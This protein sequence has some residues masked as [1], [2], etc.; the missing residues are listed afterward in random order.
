MTCKF[1]DLATGMAGA[2]L[3]AMAVPGE[4]TAAVMPPDY[5]GA[6]NSVFAVFEPTDTTAG[7]SL[8]DFDPVGDEFPLADVEPG[9]DGEA[10][11]IPNFIDP[12][13]VK[14]MRISLE[15][16]TST[17]GGIQGNDIII[18]P[19]DDFQAIEDISFL[20]SGQVLNGQSDVT[21][22]VFFDFRIL[23][24]PDWETVFIP[25]LAGAEIER[26]TIDTVSR[27]PLPAALPLFALALAG[28]G[29]AARRRAD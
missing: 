3:I 12:L 2:A 14:L 11:V 16:F 28:L 7:F 4:A 8:V 22:S 20:G 10:F 29:F 26:I 17:C 13:P 27:V 6:P 19:V 9:F 21:G 24:N 18:T 1:R 25:N 23:P 5:R 15:C